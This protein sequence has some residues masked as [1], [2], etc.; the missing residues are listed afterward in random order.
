MRRVEYRADRG[1]C[2]ERSTEPVAGHAQSGVRSQSRDMR[3]AEYGASRGTCA[4]RCTVQSRDMRRGS[5]ERPLG[6][7]PS[8]VSAAAP[9]SSF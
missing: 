2:A 8:R 3:R 9:L 6:H 4:E 7:V 1:T 5:T